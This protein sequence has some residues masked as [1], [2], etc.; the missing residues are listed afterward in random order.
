MNKFCWWTLALVLLAGC[1]RQEPTAPVLTKVPD[2]CYTGD[3]EDE[4]KY[5][6]TSD[7]ARAAARTPAPSK[8]SVMGGY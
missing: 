3:D 5:T 7:R 1:G 8:F 6:C 2:V 4:V